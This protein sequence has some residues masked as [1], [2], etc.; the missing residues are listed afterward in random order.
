M[1]S[2]RT[3][4][5][6]EELCR[7]AE[8]KFAHRFGTLDELLTELLK[9]LLRDNALVLDENEQRV[10]EERLKGLGYI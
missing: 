1:S 5:I 3:V 9:E 4:A 6:P 10:I 7:A 2:V 8:R